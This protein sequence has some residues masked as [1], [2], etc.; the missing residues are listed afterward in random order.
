MTAACT[1]RALTPATKTP[2]HVN[3]LQTLIL[4]TNIKIFINLDNT[5]V[6]CSSHTR[7]WPPGDDPRAQTPGIARAPA[8]REGQVAQHL[9]RHRRVSL[10]C[11]VDLHQTTRSSPDEA[12]LHRFLHITPKF[13][14]LGL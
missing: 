9:L 1:S 10:V 12:G 4:L 11:R 8:S 3:F 13:N 14:K 7:Q 5:A 6:P 2:R